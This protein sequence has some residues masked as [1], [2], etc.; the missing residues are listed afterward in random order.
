MIYYL[1]KNDD[2]PQVRVT[3]TR[4]NDGLAIDVSN[5]SVVLKFRKKGTSTVLSTLQSIAPSEERPEG[6]AI[7]NWGPTD[8]DISAGDYEGEI[9]ITFTSEGIVETVYETLDF[10]VREDF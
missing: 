5:A 4:E 1:V 10:V 6:I 2:G 8:L 7:F 3:L 9:E